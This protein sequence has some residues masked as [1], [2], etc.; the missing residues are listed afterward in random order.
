M[1]FSI[2]SWKRARASSTIL[3][4]H[5]VSMIALYITVLGLQNLPCFS[6]ALSKS[7]AVRVF[8][9]S[10]SPCITIPNVTSSGSQSFS[11]IIFLNNSCAWG[12]LCF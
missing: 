4:L 3:S 1:L 5:K 6:N 7:M 2:I 11:Y 9:S 12:T 8:P 10:Q